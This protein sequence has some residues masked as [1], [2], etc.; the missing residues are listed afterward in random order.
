MP[1]RRIPT[2]MIMVIRA[3]SSR[4]TGRAC[5]GVP[6]PP[7]RRQ[8]GL[9]MNRRLPD[10]VIIGAMKCATTTLHEQ[11]ARQPGITMSSPKEPNFFSD[12][13][14]DHR[15]LDWYASHFES[16]PSTTLAGEA[17]THYTKLPVHPKTVERMLRHLPEVKLV[18]VMRHPIDR[19]I[20]HYWHDFLDGK[21]QSPIDHAVQI[22]SDL[23]D[24]GR[25]AYQL[26]PY[27][28]AFG[29]SRVHPILFERLVV[30]PQ[31][32]LE[33]LGA[34]LGHDEPLLWDH[35]LKPQNVGVERMRQSR[36]RQAVVND[37]VLGP[38][39][40]M[41]VPKPLADRLKNLW[42]VKS[43]RPRLGESTRRLL[44]ARFDEDLAE[45]GGWLGVDL[46]CRNFVEVAK[47]GALSWT[48]AGGMK[49][50]RVECPTC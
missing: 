35:G 34:F 44:E 33:R 23:V 18:Y 6:P 1:D 29:P 49:E 8:W 50:R 47:R 26:K 40:R 15:G 7:V 28:E 22:H 3:P 19:L 27:F 17:S 42:R 48:P 13:A 38:I 11:L 10:F 2:L 25:F 16:G 36:L 9:Q 4:K 30:E 32:E 45:L 43:E 5:L 39:R 46:D 31:E 20:S 21:I 41:L 37:P 12:D 14:L 24:F